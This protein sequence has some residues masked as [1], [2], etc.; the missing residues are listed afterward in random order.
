[1]KDPAPRRFDPVIE[2]RAFAEAL[3][4]SHKIVRAGGMVDLNGLEAQ[5]EQLCAE[6]VKSEGQLRLELLP[7]L[8]SVIRTLSVLEEELRLC[9]RQSAQGDVADKRLRAQSAYS[10]GISGKAS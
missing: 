9:A 7:L 1:M 5:V 4:A 6:V 2:L 10:G 8:E 3:E